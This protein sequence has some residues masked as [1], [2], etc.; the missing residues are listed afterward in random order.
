M[1]LQNRSQHVALLLVGM[2]KPLLEQK[3]APQDEFQN[4][5]GPTLLLFLLPA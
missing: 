5:P 4:H 2:A 1:L 3:Y